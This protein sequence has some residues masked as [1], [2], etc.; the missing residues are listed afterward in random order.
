MVTTKIQTICPAIHMAK[1]AIGGYD[2]STT[3]Q[4]NNTRLNS[5]LSMGSKPVNTVRTVCEEDAD[6]CPITSYVLFKPCRP[7]IVKAAGKDKRA[8]SQGAQPERNMAL[9]RHS[10]CMYFCQNPVV[11]GFKGEEIRI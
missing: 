8:M 11:V 9:Y 6:S 2:P 5:V 3:F 1:S 4:K 7:I 10:C